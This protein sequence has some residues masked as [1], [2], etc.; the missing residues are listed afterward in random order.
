MLEY[1]IKQIGTDEFV[2]ISKFV[3]N[4]VKGSQ[5]V[6]SDPHTFEFSLVPTSRNID[7]PD[8]NRGDE[9]AICFDDS[10]TEIVA[11]GIVEDPGRDM[12][13]WQS[14]L[15]RPLFQY[16]VKCIEKDFSSSP[17]SELEW[18]NV[19]FSEI[20][21]DLLS[22]TDD[23]LGY[24]N[25]SNNFIK[26]VFNF[27][28]FNVDLWNFSKGTATQA[29]TELCLF[30][31]LFWV[32]KYKS[33]PDADEGLKVFKYIEFSNLSG[34][35]ADTGILSLGI[36]DESVRTELIDNP[37]VENRS[38]FP[39]IPANL[40]IEVS[41][42]PSVIC[43]YVDL[44]CNIYAENDNETL[45]RWEKKA[46]PNTYDYSLDN[47]ASD[48]VYVGTSSTSINK[49]L[50]GST[51]TVIKVSSADAATMQNND[52]II[53]PNRSK[54][55]L[56]FIDSVNRVDTTTT[57]L[58]LTEA[59]S[60]TPA[61]NETIELINNIPIF[62][63]NQTTY[64][65]IGVM[66]DID[67]SRPAKIRF[68]DLAE[69]PPG[70][71]IIVFYNKIQPLKLYAEN[72][73]S[74]A[75]YGLKYKEIVLED[76]IVLTRTEAKNLANRLLIEN[77][78]Y[79]VEITTKE[80]GIAPLGLLISFNV[81]DY[82]TES[83]TLKRRSWEYLG[84]R[85]FQG[86][87]NI[88]QTLEFTNNMKTHES[89]LKSL[90]LSRPA[91]K[92]SEELGN[93]KQKEIIKMQEFVTW[94]FQI[95]VPTPNLFA[96]YLKSIDVANGWRGTLYAKNLTTGN[97]YIVDT[98]VSIFGNWLCPRTS[99]DGKYIAYHTYDGGYDFKIKDLET[100]TIIYAV[101]DN[102][103]NYYFCNWWANDSDRIT[104]LYRNRTYTISTNNLNTSS[105]DGAFYDSF[106]HIATNKTNNI[107]YYWHSSYSYAITR[108]DIN[109][110][111]F[112]FITGGDNHFKSIFCI[113]DNEDFIYYGGEYSAFTSSK[114]YKLDLN[115]DIETVLF[116]YSDFSDYIDG[117]NIGRVIDNKFYV[118]HIIGSD[119]YLKYINLS[120]NSLNLVEQ[121]ND[122][123]Y[124][125]DVNKCYPEW[126]S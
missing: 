16:D 56:Y 69:P 93:Y 39:K 80:Y 103:G 78:Q 110:S 20:V 19:N 47:F 22:Y 124:L 52:F 38:R 27:S 92:T 4:H 61:E 76:D 95:Y 31:D 12:K 120:D 64:A 53:F 54:I 36:T 48:I 10:K 34:L 114:I 17:I 109:G 85:D 123:V 33:I 105:P 126:F 24:V 116:S 35:S 60:F 40:N 112:G 75:K 115:T 88:L 121:N 102:A 25:E 66:K 7:L 84:N 87:P 119:R 41:E 100:D 59:L 111:N 67:K 101:N 44:V 1:Y 83:L 51:D 55:D 3:R 82:L 72:S 11:H 29:L 57:E 97:E 50:A 77:V 106:K 15:S 62:I 79:D 46:L 108:R 91:T 28:D 125:C 9:I 94:D 117:L 90:K 43:N 71:K 86:K 45:T 81:T 68:T 118:N 26:Y 49:T 2:N 18:N 23:S 65:D 70:T 96:F 74:I 21:E 89:I 107:V 5:E 104:N 73:D 99:K 32:I 37:I 13:T 58:T 14:S 98:N 6:N 63:E 8:I 30:F 42:D 113:D 122:M